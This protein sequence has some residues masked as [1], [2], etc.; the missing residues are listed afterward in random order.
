VCLTSQKKKLENNQKKNRQQQDLTRFHGDASVWSELCER[1]R[2]FLFCFLCVQK[3]ERRCILQYSG[4]LCSPF[5]HIV[6]Q[7]SEAFS[8][9]ALRPASV[10]RFFEQAT[11]TFVVFFCSTLFAACSIRVRRDERIESTFLNSNF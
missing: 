10:A 8:V 5:P 6:P 3:Q 1:S 7:V 4:G 2:F 11:S 9:A